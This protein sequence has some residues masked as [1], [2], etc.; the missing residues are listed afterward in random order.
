VDRAQY[1]VRDQADPLKIGVMECWSNGVSVMRIEDGGLR[2][3]RAILILVGAIMF[4]APCWAQEKVRFPLGASSKV[5]SYSPLW[6]AQKMGFFE[7]EG[8]EAQIVV[9]RG[10]PI[11]IQALATESIYVANAGTDGIIS[12][13]DRG[14]DLAMIGSL[15]NGLSMSLVAA[16]PY[17]TFEDLRGK[18]IGSQTITTGTGFA[19]RLVLR[20]HGLEYPRDYQLLN[21][22][23][24]SDRFTALQTGQIAAVPLSVPLDITAKQQGFNVLGYFADDLP[25]YF[26][27][28]YTVKRSWAEKNRSLVV[29]FMKAMAQAHRW[30]FD[31]RDAACSY[32]SKEMALTMENCRFA[33]D[34]NVKNRIWDR[35][36]DL[37]LDGV[38]TMIKIVAE[39]NNQKEPLA[40]PAK[41]IDQSYLKQALAEIKK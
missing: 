33:W 17:K 7:R 2:I 25:H 13:V 37:S 26:L 27:N 39:I 24:A 14:L 4:S 21:I 15:I 31:N 10:T 34:Y 35:N 16:K 20:A 28:P 23:G 9:M 22:G 29:R 32:L 12:A 1:A 41:Y 11:T 19:L 18:T 8:L 3:A 40:P 36:A 38:R 30:L 6:I 5:I